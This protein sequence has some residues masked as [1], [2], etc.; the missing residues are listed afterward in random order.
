MVKKS[1]ITKSW[2]LVMPQSLWTKLQEH[3][4]PGDDEEHGAVITAGVV[5]TSREDRLLARELFVAKDGEDYVQG[6]YG[7]RMLK[8]NFIRDKILYCRE[9]R[10]AY[11][12]VHCHGGSD[13]VRFSLTDLASHERGY[14]AL[15]DIVGG[16]PVGAIV[17]SQNA[18]AGD[19]WL[20]DGKRATIAKT[21]IIGTTVQRIYPQP[22]SFRTHADAPYERQCRIFGDRGQDM[23]SKLKVG[24][25]G[26]GGAGSLII[27]H[28]AR[29]GVGH[30]V[31]ADPDHIDP[32]NK[33]RVVGSTDLDVKNKAKKVAVAKRVA[34]AANSK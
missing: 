21:L 22:L 14:P 34:E 32:T 6:E 9:Q 15:R 1:R 13:S 29:L 33:P 19:I 4:F 10:L 28:I 3:L 26:A 27:E 17:T 7:Y 25:I 5:Q 24:V 16:Q 31:I 12:A 8:A 20:P 30:I 23:L 11:L 2:T 18:I